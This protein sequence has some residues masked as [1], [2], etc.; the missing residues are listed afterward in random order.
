[1]IEIIEKRFSDNGIDVGNKASILFAFYEMLIEWNKK[2]NLTSIIEFEDVVEK[3]FVDSCL[4][5][6][7]GLIK[8]GSLCIDVGTGAG[9]PGIPLA[10]MLDEAHFILLEARGKR[11]LFLA[12]AIE[13]LGLNNCIN[14]CGRAELMAHEKAHRQT[15]DIAMTRAVSSL[16]T[17][18]EYTLPFIKVGGSSIAYRGREHEEIDLD[19]LKELG[20]ESF[21][22]ID[23]DVCGMKREFIVVHKSYQTGDKYPRSENSIKKKPLFI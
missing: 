13:K 8:Q 2:I 5:I 15:Y 7:H 19:A 18:L 22:R 3:H 1:M 4:P 10:I 17:V 16:S 11:N 12:E 20:S 6:K 14:I 9:F 21:D 23:E